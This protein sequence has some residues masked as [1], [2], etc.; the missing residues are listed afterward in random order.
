VQEA[1]V[2]PS[3]RKPLV[4]LHAASVASKA[5]APP[6]FIRLARVMQ[7]P[8]YAAI[9]TRRC[10]VTNISCCRCDWQGPWCASEQVYAH[11]PRQP[12][13]QLEMRSS[14]AWAA[15]VQHGPCCTHAEP[16]FIDDPTPFPKAR[17]RPAD[18]LQPMRGQRND[19]MGSCVLPSPI[20]AVRIEQSELHVPDTI[21]HFS[22]SQA[23]SQGD[24][25]T[26]YTSATHHSRPP[27]RWLAAQR[28]HPRNSR[29]LSR[30]PCVV[31]RPTAAHW[32]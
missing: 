22:H 2:A 19:C 18:C 20:T 30:Q 23:H 1:A 27:L 25:S 5:L 29:H 14:R 6:G 13:L 3:A 10:V 15:A 7:T 8:D 12:G 26:R 4:C 31:G 24:R 28:P 11:S 16:R 32:M 9:T 21:L 17:P